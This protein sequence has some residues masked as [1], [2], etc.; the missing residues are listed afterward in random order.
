MLL[1]AGLAV[2]AWGVG[3]IGFPAAARLL[4]W[5]GALLQLFVSA[6]NVGMGAQPLYEA[7]PVHVLAFVV[8]LVVQ[9]PIYW[10]AIYVVLR[11]KGGRST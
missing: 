9:V 2:L 8:G 5:P 7:T 6:P 3:E 4:V 11:A 1:S 10:A